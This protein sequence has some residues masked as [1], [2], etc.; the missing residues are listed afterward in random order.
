MSTYKPVMTYTELKSRIESEN[1]LNQEQTNFLLDSLNYAFESR[2][3]LLELFYEF[4][5]SHS[6]F[7]EIE[8]NEKQEK[9]AHDLLLQ[10]MNSFE[11]S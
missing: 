2:L 6:L 9:L 1:I 10:I 3:P 4:F 5:S 7:N 11:V 8:F